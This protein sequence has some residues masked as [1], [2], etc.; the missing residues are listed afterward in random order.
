MFNRLGSLSISW[1]PWAK[2]STGRWLQVD[3]G[4]EALQRW[5]AAQRAGGKFAAVGDNGRFYTFLDLAHQYRGEP[6]TIVTVLEKAPPLDQA[7]A[8]L[9]IAYLH[10][11]LAY[12]HRPGYDEMMLT[13]AEAWLRKGKDA[14]GQ[15]LSVAYHFVAARVVGWQGGIKEA[16][17]HIAAVETLAPN[18]F[19]A[20]MLRV[21]LYAWQT[22]MQQMIYAY[23]QAMKV[24]LTTTRKV[25]MRH[26]LGQYLTWFGYPELA[27]NIYRELK[28]LKPYD[29]WLW[30][31]MSLNHLRQ[32]RLR[33][34]AHCNQN[35]L[36]LQDFAAARGL[37]KQI[38]AEWRQRVVTFLGGVAI[39]GGL[40]L[41]VS[42]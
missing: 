22:D 8:A 1:L 24:A 27:L 32:H 40:L 5:W 33:L 41:L 12:R 37:Q 16:E 34:A 39:L 13:Q 25:H 30:H 4:T 21:E 2:K 3:S 38:Q 7:T 42:S 19:F 10:T 15:E 6:A 9:A 20:Q 18:S 14:L 29:P 28:E 26:M 11:L 36:S 23:R 35:S 17:K 31:Y